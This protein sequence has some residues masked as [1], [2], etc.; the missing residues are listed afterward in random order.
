MRM[1]TSEEARTGKYLLAERRETFFRTDTPEGDELLEK[2]LHLE[3]RGLATHAERIDEDGDWVW[4]FEL[5][6]A[7]RT[8]LACYDAAVKAGCR[9]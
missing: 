4:R 1:L 2:L 7:G 6:T 3:E 8:A 5:T 9:P